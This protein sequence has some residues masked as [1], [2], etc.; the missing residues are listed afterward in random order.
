[1]VL[2]ISASV[3]AED[4]APQVGVT[5][6]GTAGGVVDIETTWDDGASWRP[7][8]GGSGLPTVG[9]SVFVRDHVPALNVPISY[10]VTEG[11]T[12]VASAALT[13]SSPVAWLQD[14]LEPRSAVPVS[15]TRAD[16]RLL[17]LSDSLT[18]LSSSQMVDLVTP[19]GSRLP[20]AS[21]ARRRGPAAMPMHVRAALGSQ[22]DLVA[23]LRRLWETAGQI[24]VRGLPAGIPLDP[25]AHI[26]APDVVESP[27]QQGVVGEWC[28]WAWTAVQARPTSL[29]IVV[30]WWT[31]DQV[32]D[33]WQS[34]ADNTYAEVLL[35]RPGDTYLD[36][37]QDP[38]EP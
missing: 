38:T 21:M 4:G 11:P 30:P 35:A 25:V 23:K 5:V 32:R 18:S 37:A 10:R 29:R 8:R 31:Y 26:V 7:I 16:D 15:P 13:V 28:E 34:T 19:H 20:V 22:G 3:L 24:V 33:I 27:V 17:L 2:A 36:W 12:V 9:G 1:M 6:T 14:P